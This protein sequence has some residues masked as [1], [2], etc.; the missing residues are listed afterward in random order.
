[1]TGKLERVLFVDDQPEILELLRRQVGSS[2]DCAYAVSGAEALSLLDAEGPFAAVVVDYALPNMDGITLLAEFHRRSPDT[3]P[4]MLTAYGDIDIAIAAL[5][6]G[7]VFRF[8][9]K[10]WDRAELDRALSNALDQFHLVQR[11]RRLRDELSQANRALD[12]RLREV[13]GLHQMLAHWVDFSPAVLFSADCAERDVALTYVSQNVTR[14]LGH[15][16]VDVIKEPALWEQAVHPDDAP[17]RTRRLRE[18]IDGRSIE[19]T[20]RHRVRRRDGG[21]RQVAEGLRCLRNP[22]GKALEVVGA[23][24]DLGPA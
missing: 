9:R 23:W 21:W 1:M 16:R 12:A 24:L 14:L 20:L 15:E 6:Q 5:H 18:F 8:L 22:Q 7:H 11:E 13:D 3:V 2:Y 19:L 4:L 10:P 17:E